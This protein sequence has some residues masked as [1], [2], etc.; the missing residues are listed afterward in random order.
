MWRKFGRI[1][2][3]VETAS[4]DKGVTEEAGKSGSILAD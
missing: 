2:K 3:E 1:E 4:K